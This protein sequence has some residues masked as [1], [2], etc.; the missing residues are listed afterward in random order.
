[1]IDWVGWIGPPIVAIS[2]GAVW[3]LSLAAG[4]ALDQPKPQ[5]TYLYI[6]SC[7]AVQVVVMGAWA[8]GRALG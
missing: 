8:A 1:M 2:A 5:S 3:L 4:Y 7:V 6:G